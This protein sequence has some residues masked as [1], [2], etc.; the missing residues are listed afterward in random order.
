[1]DITIQMR[2]LELLIKML[3]RDMEG[4]PVYGYSRQMGSLPVLSEGRSL[5]RCT[6]EEAGLSST[7]VER[8]FRSLSDN[9]AELGV[10]SVMLLRHGRVFAEGYYAPYR[11]GIPHMLYSASKSIVSTA[12]GM[13]VDEGLLDIDERLEDI[14][15][16]YT[17]KPA[18][19]WSKML[20]IRHLL[21]MSTGVRFNEVGS[22]LD[23]DWV[24]MFMESAPKFEPGT[25][26]EYNSLNTYMLSAVLR[27]KTGVS[28]TEFLTPRLYEPL[29]IRSHHWETCPKGTE[30]GGWG[31]SLCI[32]DLA[33]I[34]Q[35]Y[36]N[37]G[38]WEGRRLLSEEWISAATSPRISTPNGEM[39]HGYGYQF[40]GAFGQYAVMFP[41]YDA[42]AIIYSGSTQLFAK[43][44]LM[45]LLD[46]CFWACSGTELAPYPAGYDS[47]KAYLAGLVFSPGSSRKGLGTDKAAFNK[48]R[49]LLDGR[50]FRLFDN[51]GSLFPQPLQNVHGCYSRGA[52]II[53]FS[54]TENGLAVTFYEQCERNTVYMAMDGSFTDSVFV[55]KEEH[56][57]VSTRG[58]WSAGEGEACITLFTSFLETPDTRIIELR[59]LNDAIEAV[60]N[61]TPTAE[62][63][64][65]ML[66]E[67]VGLVDDSSMKRLLPAMKHVPGMSESTMTDIV[68]KYAAPRSFGREI[69]LH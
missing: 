13:A 39:K 64:A 61:E 11:P 59:I 32:E 2:S 45:Q 20:T 69:R 34:A 41:Q 68:K 53:R 54:S 7:V 47:L 35:L 19:R 25:Q 38:V 58:I 44:S 17:G 8:F 22:A 46:S 56:H 9:S 3:K 16:G 15:P 57:L 43:T 50:E 10:H 26:F 24:K 5:P 1:M 4:I 63:A 30:K 60:F 21:T 36:L 67:L 27:K 66:L 31:L 28:L 18:S 12:V 23:E 42:A 62:G 14:F 29:D 51:Y 52:D 6:P 49:A 48:I 33:K 65:K 37:K 55:M 40:N